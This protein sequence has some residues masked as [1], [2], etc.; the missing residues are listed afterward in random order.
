MIHKPCPLTTC[1]FN[2]GFAGIACCDILTEV[3]ECKR[4]RT[5]VMGKED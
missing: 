5:I 1:Q 3:E 2:R 4:Y